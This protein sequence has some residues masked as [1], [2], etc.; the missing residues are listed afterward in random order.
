MPKARPG[1]EF[2]CFSPDL[3]LR[4]LAWLPGLVSSAA[5]R[6]AVPGLALWVKL[7]P[8]WCR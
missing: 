1:F 5:L 7:L 6:K 4:A 3:L 8:V 2:F